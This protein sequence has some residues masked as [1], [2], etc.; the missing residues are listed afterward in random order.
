MTIAG[1]FL[2]PLKRLCSHELNN[3]NGTTKAAVRSVLRG[4]SRTVSQRETTAANISI[5]NKI[6][7][8]FLTETV[9]MPSSTSRRSIG[10]DAALDLGDAL[11]VAEDHGGDGDCAS[12]DDRYDRDQQAA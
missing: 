8:I 6:V 7:L 11:L 2:G 5:Q 12:H 1:R 3:T 10:I 9:L 4:S